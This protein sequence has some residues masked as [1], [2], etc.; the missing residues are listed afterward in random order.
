M[1]YYIKV[2]FF[3][4]ILENEFLY[5]NDIQMNLICKQDMFIPVNITGLEIHIVNTDYVLYIKG[6]FV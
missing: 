6:A 3:T 5:I 1:T 4:D 2:V